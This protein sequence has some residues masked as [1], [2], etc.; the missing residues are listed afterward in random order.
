VRLKKLIAQGFKSFKDR[1]VV[2]FDH[3]ITGIVGPNG[4]GK[5]NIVDALFWVMGEQ[6]AKHLRGSSMRDVIFAGASKYSPAPWAEVTLL[7]ENSEGKHIHI[8]NKVVSP[9]E[10][11]ISR[12]LYRNGES[13]YRIN[14]AQCR[15]KDIQE[16]FMDTGAGAKSY[17]IIAQGEIERLVQAKPQER[18]VM[19]EEVAG[20]TKFKARKRESLRKMEQTASNLSRL[21]DLQ[22]EIEKNLKVLEEQAQKA[23]RGRTLKERVQRYQLIVS[24]DQEAKLLKQFDHH[25]QELEHLSDKL[26]NNHSEKD[27]LELD[28]SAERVRRDEQTE[29]LD[30]EQKAFNQRSTEHATTAERINSLAKMSEAKDEQIAVRRKE[31]VE[32]EEELASRQGRR[33]EIAQQLEQLL[34]SATS[35]ADLNQEREQ[36]QDLK[37]QSEEREQGQKELREKLEQSTRHYTTQDS[38]LYKITNR[39]RELALSLQEGNQ[40]REELE[41]EF[42]GLKAKI[43]SEQNELADLAT[44]VVGLEA[45]ELEYKGRV[46]EKESSVRTLKDELHESR[47]ELMLR[48][49]QLTSLKEL[50]HSL[51]GIQEGAAALMRSGHGK[52]H[53]L[54][55]SML[56]CETRFTSAV[57]ASL[58]HLLELVVS[59]NDSDQSPIYQWCS[60]GSN[61]ELGLDYFV[62][63]GVS[64][65]SEESLER[66]KLA[67][68]AEQFGEIHSLSEVIKSTEQEF[69]SSIDN[70]LSD[71]YIVSDLTLEAV[72]LL[73][74]N[75][76][77]NSIV[78]MDGKVV[79]SRQRGGQ[80]VTLPSKSSAAPGVVDRNNR[81]AKLQKELL[82]RSSTI[83]QMESTLD[84]ATRER[85]EIRHRYQ[86]TK[87]ELLK[88]KAV[89]T[90]RQS[91]QDSQQE[92][93]E[94]SERRL[95]LLRGRAEE[96]SKE[97]LSN[98][99]LE[100]RLTAETKQLQFE[101]TAMQENLATDQKALEEIQS[102][103]RYRHEVLLAREI[104]AQSY[105]ERLDNIDGQM[106]DID[107]QIETLGKRLESNAETISKLEEGVTQGAIEIAQFEE[108]NRVLASQLQVEEH[109]LQQSTDKLSTLLISM[110]D[111][112]ERV[113]K[114]AEEI[115]KHESKMATS[116]LKCGHIKED[117]ERL[118][119]DIFEKYRVNLRSTISTYLKWDYTLMDQLNP[120]ESML[121][122]DGEDGEVQ[123]ES[124]PF[125]FSERQPHEVKK[126]QQKLSSS[127]SEFNQLGE[128]NWQA[129]EEYE[130]QQL[131][132]KFLKEQEDE[133]KVS[134]ADLRQAIDHIDNK[135]HQRFQQ[136][137]TEVNTRFEKVFPVIF[138]GGQGRLEMVGSIDQDDDFGVDI[139]ASP[140]GKKMQNINLMSGGEKAMTAVSLIF[141]IFLVKPSPFCLLDEVDAPLDDANIG[142]FTELLREMSSK[143]QFIVI[144]HNKKTMELND[145]LY[146]ITMQ[147]PGISKA[148]SI[149][150]Q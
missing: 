63:D 53:R 114:L 34:L 59:Q 126:Y 31:Q 4:C 66:L 5:S 98:L 8:G 146:G 60:E 30:Q 33:D 101:L 133:L 47:R 22:Q 46:S 140:P 77:F 139:I 29:Q 61:R 80:I 24:S 95:K 64:S 79:V 110:Q 45:K 84:S 19:I 130:R 83:E 125:D 116:E 43:S 127:R 27:R 117:E 123:I 94:V 62:R 131:R 141:S 92:A 147:D 11:Q 71:S 136:A 120:L 70:I 122:Q 144:T 121:V 57:E 10:I 149:Q 112:E 105:Q 99:E 100:E 134:L 102:N 15:L 20:I 49:S 38:E 93:S 44:K 90:A 50:A 118:A 35:A 37:Q 56:N 75:L 97:R 148:I 74:A 25:Q 48:E 129:I 82:E 78:S 132:H 3:G 104:E 2:T 81:V 142:R 16:I 111:R 124:V 54:L 145:T 143:S 42:S 128:I 85:E 6:S 107:Q 135:S 150:L 91:L 68:P 67:L 13:E 26:Q 73:P 96:S 119:R 86:Q 18:R 36:C 51:D 109:A 138:G 23:K 7:M 72:K 32:T 21:A 113:K 58:G 106:R 9:T 137:F 14:G 115:A 89:L 87:E 52:D 55:G 40:E 65:S 69:S 41:R 39:L 103:Y 1:T 108:S 88:Q 76:H 28:L 17:S 12:K